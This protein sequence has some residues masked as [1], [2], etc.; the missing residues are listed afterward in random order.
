[1][2][3]WVIPHAAIRG[4]VG[5]AGVAVGEVTNDPERGRPTA[6]HLRE[7]RF[8]IDN[9]LGIPLRNTAQA[10]QHEKKK[11]TGQ[12]RLKIRG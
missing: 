11:L 10:N 4:Q 8:G 6:V 9:G 12:H 1:M 7:Q 5:H 3:P 2:A